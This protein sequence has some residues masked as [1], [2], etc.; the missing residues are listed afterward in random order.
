MLEPPLTTYDL[1]PT[2]LT[3]PFWDA[4]R[5]GKLLVQHCRACARKFFRPEIACPH[6]RSR[7]WDWVESNG[8]GK[9]YSFSVMHRSPSPAFKAPFIFAAIEMEEGWSLFS[10]LIGL[11]IDEAAIGMPVEVCFH[12]VSDDLT[13]PLFRPAAS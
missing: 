5:A 4:A 11:D 6:C 8:R 9:L 2:E 13:V 7:E 1:R 12:A 10:N 3:Q